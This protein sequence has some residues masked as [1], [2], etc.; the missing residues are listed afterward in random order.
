MT[1]LVMFQNKYPEGRFMCPCGETE[2]GEAQAMLCHG[3]SDGGAIGHFKRDN[4][5]AIALCPKCK[6]PGYLFS[7]QSLWQIHPTNDESINQWLKRLYRSGA[8]L[9]N[10]P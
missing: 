8:S 7:R 9:G 4:E 2:R 1:Q 10:L 3:W 5:T 6:A